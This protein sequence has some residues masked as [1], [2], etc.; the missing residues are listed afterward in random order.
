MNIMWVNLNGINT[1]LNIDE[2]RQIRMWEDNTAEIT[3][4]NGNKQIISEPEMAA[5][6]FERIANLS[7]I[8]IKE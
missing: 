7:T 3:W 2:M 1:L 5:K 6:I 8:L 4:R